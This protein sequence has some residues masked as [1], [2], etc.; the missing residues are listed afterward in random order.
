MRP[1][2]IFLAALLFCG[3]VAFSQKHN[4]VKSKLSNLLYI[5]V[6]NPITIYKTTPDCQVSLKNGTL[7][8]VDLKAKDSCT[9]YIKVDASESKPILTIKQGKE[10]YSYTFRKRKIP[11]PE[12]VL[13]ATGNNTPVK[14]S[15]VPFNYF[16]KIQGFT[17]DLKDFDFDINFKVQSYGLTILKKNG[18]NQEI[19][20]TDHDISKFAQ[21]AEGGDIFI[22][23]DI[24][25]TCITTG[26][27]RV[28]EDKV[29]RVR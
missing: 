18:E 14:E 20:G 25:I 4:L 13:R 21:Y 11:N 1:K 5:G 3:I 26:E 6:E 10:V 29:Y 7:T 8:P 19:Q 27:E 24:H 16:R 2:F 23:H 15:P 17:L 9:Y 22:F 28:L 12:F